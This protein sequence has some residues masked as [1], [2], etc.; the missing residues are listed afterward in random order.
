MKNKIGLSFVSLHSPRET[1]NFIQTWYEETGT[2]PNFELSYKMDSSF[3]KDIVSIKGKVLSA[4]VPCPGSEYLPNFG[5]RNASV[6]QSSINSIRESA[7]AVVSFGGNILV[8]HAG[9]T[10][11]T[12]VFT[13]YRKRESILGTY[14]N[15]N[16]YLLMEE[17]SI[18]NYKYVKSDEYKLHMRV[19]IENLKKAADICMEKGIKLAVENLNPRLTYLFQLPEDFILM[20]R[21]IKNIFICI[22]IGHL[23]ISSL[24]HGFDYFDALNTLLETGRVISV[25][26][27][28]NKSVSGSH[29]YYND[30]HESIGKGN[31]PIKESISIL[32]E[33]SSANLIIEAVSEPLENL[34]TLDRYRKLSSKEP[35]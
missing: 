19:T 12:L 28:D 27:H 33:K 16:I 14:K 10:L 34:R 18:C 32:L 35:L 21:E 2:Y 23:W 24:V 30:D 5:S 11:D 4:H 13:E 9:Y 7:D 8:L 3:L 1:F 17:G 29:P 22:D 6:I 31:V 26:I 15:K 20:T 25:H